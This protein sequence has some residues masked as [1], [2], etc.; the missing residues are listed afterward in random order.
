MARKTFFSFQ[1]R[2]NNSHI[3][4]V[5]NILYNRNVSKNVSKLG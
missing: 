2:L 5:I 3:T 1:Y 4:N